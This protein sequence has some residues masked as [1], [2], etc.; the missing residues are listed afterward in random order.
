M[1]FGVPIKNH[2]L[3]LT[4]QSKSELRAA[5]K[6]LAEGIAELMGVEVP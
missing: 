1:V 5:N 3:N 2:I 4:E 6:L